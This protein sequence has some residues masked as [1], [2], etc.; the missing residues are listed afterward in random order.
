MG[1][2]QRPPSLAEQPVLHLTLFMKVPHD[3]VISVFA[4]TQAAGAG[5]S[6]LHCLVH[7]PLP[8]LQGALTLAIVGLLGAAFYVLLAFQSQGPAVVSQTPSL[9]AACACLSRVLEH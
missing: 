8:A 2:V 7:L 9:W 6:G 5:G 4:A 1:A 3:C